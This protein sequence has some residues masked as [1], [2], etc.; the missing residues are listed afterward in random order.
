MLPTVID[1]DF[2]LENGQ[3]CMEI[4]QVGE[5]GI[6]NSMHLTLPPPYTVEAEVAYDFPFLHVDLDV[7]ATEEEEEEILFGLGE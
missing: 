3:F 4:P 5:K 1:K 6:T 7:L 2:T